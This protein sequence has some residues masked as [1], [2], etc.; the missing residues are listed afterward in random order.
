[1]WH[2]ILQILVGSIIGALVG[3]SFFYYSQLQSKGSL[4][5]KEEQW[6]PI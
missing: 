5:M 2:S 4:A 3:Y 6:A 1:M